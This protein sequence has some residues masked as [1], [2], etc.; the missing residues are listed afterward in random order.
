M[1]DLWAS[2]P[3]GYLFFGGHG[4]P[5]EFLYNHTGTAVDIAFE[6]ADAAQLN[7]LRPSIGYAVGCNTTQPEVAKTC[8]GRCSNRAGF[9]CGRHPRIAPQR[10][11]E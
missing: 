2:L 10:G 6:S 11:M 8:P 9:L 4:A 1:V 5:D 3:F 7:D